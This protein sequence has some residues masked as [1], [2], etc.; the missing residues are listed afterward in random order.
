MGMDSYIFKARTK[1][2]FKA[3]NWY[4]DEN[5]TEVWTGRKFWD[6]VENVSFIKD[7]NE[8]SGEFIQLT[9]SNIEEMIQ[10]ATHNRDYWGGFDSVP[11][12]CEIL[13]HFDDDEEAGWHYYFEFDY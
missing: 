11:T 13:D 4:S 12:L 5:I 9:K 10:I 3:E 8:D 1:K 7:I 2:A 6:I